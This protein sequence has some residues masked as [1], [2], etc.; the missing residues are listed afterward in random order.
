MRDDQYNGRINVEKSNSLLG[1]LYVYNK[2]Q[3]GKPI[4]ERDGIQRDK[5]AWREERGGE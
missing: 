5:S 2:T 4:K 1:R 3:R